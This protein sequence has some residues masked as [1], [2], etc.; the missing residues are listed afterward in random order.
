M[1]LCIYGTGGLAKEVYDIVVRSS[2]T[3]YENIF[4]VNDYLPEGSFYMNK[5]I[6]FESI[7]KNFDSINAIEGIV[8]V[9]EP[10][11]RE[12]LS[13]RLETIGIKLATIIDSTAI[14]S[15]SAKIGEGSII[16]EYSTIHADSCLGKSVLIQSYCDIGHDII[17]GDYS[18]V[19]TGCTPGGGD[20]IG[21]RT[22]LGMNSSIKEKITIG[23]D[24]IIGMGAV[25]FQDIMDGATVVGNPARVTKGKKEHHVF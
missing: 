15:S 24:V 2:P 12:L 4:F 14:V 3:K 9:G 1:I 5:M 20:I 19:S 8:A 25:V 16:C 6:K 13:K 21:K 7:G 10:I 23:D 22:Y 17:I 11:H 18:V